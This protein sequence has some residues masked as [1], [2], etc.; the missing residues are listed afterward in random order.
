MN[1]R[2]LSRLDDRHPAMRKTED[3][4]LFLHLPRSG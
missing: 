1:R 2:H 3:V 4:D